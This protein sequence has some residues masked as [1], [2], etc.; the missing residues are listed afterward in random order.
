MNICPHP[1]R[2]HE[3]Y[4]ALQAA[5]TERRISNEPPVPLI[6]NGWIMSSDEEKAERWIA[7]EQWARNYGLAKL[8]EVPPEDWYTSEL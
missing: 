1:N 5:C 2:W 8:L 6:L 4:K 3:I 7:T